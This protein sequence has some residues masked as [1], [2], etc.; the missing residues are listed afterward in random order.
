[1]V[2]VGLGSIVVTAS[3]MLMY[4]SARSYAALANYVDLDQ[5]SRKALDV[6][7]KHIRQADKVN[8]ASSSQIVMS[9]GGLSSNL[10]FTFNPTTRTLVYTNGT[11]HETLLSECDSLTFSIY[12][13][14]TASNTF[15]QFPAATAANAKLIQISWTCSRTILGR[16]VNTES[17]QSAKIVIRKQDQM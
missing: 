9:Y 5:Y 11:D 2:A 6:L 12:Q 4:F 10:S 8:Y 1:M 14:N 17:V 13:R 7:S 3:A 16:K 15:D